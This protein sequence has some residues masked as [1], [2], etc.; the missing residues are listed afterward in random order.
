MQSQDN[1]N[2]WFYIY[3]QGSEIM[4]ENQKE[5]PVSWV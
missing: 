3:E 5:K 2:S 4:C 1:Q